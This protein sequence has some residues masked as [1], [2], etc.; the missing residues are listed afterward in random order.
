MQRRVRMNRRGIANFELRRQIR[1]PTHFPQHYSERHDRG[2][3][4]KKEDYA[5]TA[6]CSRG[7]SK[8]HF[9][10]SFVGMNFSN[11]WGSCYLQVFVNR[12]YFYFEDLWACPGT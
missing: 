6:F 2:R 7:R 3:K 12:I 8:T 5:L 1:P 9:V 10:G 4:K 11:I